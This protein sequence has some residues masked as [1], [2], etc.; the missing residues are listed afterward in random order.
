MSAPHA[1]PREDGRRAAASSRAARRERSKE[2]DDVTGSRK[3]V[4]IVGATTEKAV[5][6]GKMKK[7]LWDEETHR[8][9]SR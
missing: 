1:R 6:K 4:R 8:R 3:R 5:E 9:R 2:R 7:D